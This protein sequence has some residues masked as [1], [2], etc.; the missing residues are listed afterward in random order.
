M[1]EGEAYVILICSEKMHM[2]KFTNVYILIR[3][4]LRCRK[5][6]EKCIFCIFCWGAAFEQLNVQPVLVFLPLSLETGSYFVV[7]IGLG[8]VALSQSHDDP[9]Y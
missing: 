4:W 5:M 9:E 3:K 6:Q 8:Y 2:K 7:H 1:F